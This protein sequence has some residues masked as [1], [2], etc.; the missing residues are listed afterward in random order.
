MLQ[1]V[2]I[3][4]IP[5][6]ST[7]TTWVLNRAASFMSDM[8]GDVVIY[9]TADVRSTNY[10]IRQ[11]LLAGAVEELKLL[12]E[13]DYDRIIVVGHSLGSV[14]AYDALNRIV[15]D[16]NAPGGVSQEQAQKI[17]GLVTFG[18]PLDKVAFFFREQTQDTE[19]VRRQILAHLHGFK[20]HP[21]NWVDQ[22][23]RIGNPVRSRLDGAQWLN[24]YHSKDP[25]SGQ[26]DAYAVTENIPCDE[27]QVKG[28]G[29]AHNVYWRCDLMY[30]KIVTSFFGDAPGSSRTA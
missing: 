22:D 9:S 28:S 10:A 2:G 20:S 16:L 26:L 19:V 1:R 6:I 25:V 23:V 7:L 24:F 12:L 5:V 30:K 18:S 27:M 4:K 21:S 11:R 8:M 29:E 15:T 13:Q 3:A 17:A 14:I